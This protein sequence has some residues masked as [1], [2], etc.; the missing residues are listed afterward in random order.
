[1]V[2]KSQNRST[3]NFPRI[4]WQ[5]LLYKHPVVLWGGVWLALLL[6][7]AL[8][9]RG[10]MSPGKAVQQ[11]PKAIMSAAAQKAMPETTPSSNVIDPNSLPAFTKVPQISPA[12]EPSRGVPMWLYG[13]IAISSAIGSVLISLG[14][15][16]K[17]RYR[18]P[19]K[20]LNKSINR[21]QSAPTRKRQQRNLPPVAR[22]RRRQVKNLHV[23]SIQTAYVPEPVVTVLPAENSYPRHQ[24]SEDLAEMMDLRKR[25][26]L[27]SLLGGD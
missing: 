1:M 12:P 3:Q 27:T 25:Q 9:V 13:T 23:T 5:Q 4:W 19:I 7:G 18:K 20:R 14:F 17:P 6:V 11:Q 16:H 22:K 24:G 2:T 15:K 26:S 21:S 8:A 10:L